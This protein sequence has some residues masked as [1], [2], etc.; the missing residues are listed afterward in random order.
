MASLC[1]L[2]A[3]QALPAGSIAAV[4]YQ[5][6][7]RDRW[8]LL[9]PV[10]QLPNA[11]QISTQSLCGLIKAAAAVDAQELVGLLCR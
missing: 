8:H 7:S 2:S 10:L 4:L 1:S 3:A 5:G 11:K 6:I 9:R